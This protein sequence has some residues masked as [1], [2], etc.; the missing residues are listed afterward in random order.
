MASLEKHSSGGAARFPASERIKSI[1]TAEELFSKGS[2]YYLY[3]FRILYIKK[4]DYSEGLPQILISVPKRNFKKAIDRNRLKRQIR[5]AYRLN[6][7]GIFESLPK[8]KIPAFIGI[9]FTSKEKLPYKVLEEKLI[10]ILQR[11]SK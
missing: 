2:S 1:K 3:P 10:L 5:E 9:I 7:Q 6:K 11:L 8:D 4:S